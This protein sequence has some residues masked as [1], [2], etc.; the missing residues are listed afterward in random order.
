MTLL[1][2]WEY[3]PSSHSGWKWL[4]CIGLIA[5]HAH[6]AANNGAC[7]S[8][9]NLLV[10]LTREEKGLF[11][12]AFRIIITTTIF[13][14]KTKL[15][16]RSDLLVV[17]GHRKSHRNGTWSEMLHWKSRSFGGEKCV[18][19]KSCN[20]QIPTTKQQASFVATT[21]ELLTFI[22][23]MKSTRIRNFSYLVSTRRNTAHMGM[24]S[25]K[26]VV[27]VIIITIIGKLE[28]Q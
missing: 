9:R 17:L 6:L 27:V 23:M 16:H 21:G 4:L 12:V 19:F 11:S 2:N 25:I 28:Q 7:I 24:V 1:K 15:K 22:C 26:V 14:P 3:I 8:A 13:C 20:H 18:Y 10:Y 5:R